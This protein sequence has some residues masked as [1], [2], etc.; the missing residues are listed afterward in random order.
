V[1]VSDVMAERGTEM[2]R[3]REIREVSKR[4][5]KRGVKK[6]VRKVGRKWGQKEGSKREVKTALQFSRWTSV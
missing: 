1:A 6:R 4:G 2:A 5:V 3:A